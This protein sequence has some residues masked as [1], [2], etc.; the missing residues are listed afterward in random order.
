M[1]PLNPWQIKLR[2]SL[3]ETND[4]AEDSYEEIDVPARIR[5]VKRFSIAIKKEAEQ[6]I[7]SFC[8]L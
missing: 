2:K 3:N 6:R 8:L 5:S 7:A 4:G 1:R